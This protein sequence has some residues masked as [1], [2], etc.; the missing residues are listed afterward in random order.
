[1]LN[2]WKK[3]LNSLNNKEMKLLQPKAETEKIKAEFE[4][5]SAELQGAWDQLK[6]TTAE[7]GKPTKG[8]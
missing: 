4:A 8:I 1:M 7:F 3:S 6:R 2:K 5:K